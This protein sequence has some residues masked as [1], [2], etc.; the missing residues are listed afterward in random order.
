MV[1]GHGCRREDPNQ[2]CVL[3]LLR[4][5]Y[6]EKKYGKKSMEKKYGKKIVREK[7]TGKKNGKNVR[8]GKYGKKSKAGLCHF[9]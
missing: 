9:R 7:N 4:K 3:L 6:G 5:K 8:G 2:H 1:I